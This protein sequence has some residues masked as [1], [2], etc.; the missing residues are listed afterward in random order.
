M[1]A[2]GNAPLTP[3]GRLDTVR[4]VAVG[5]RNIGRVARDVGVWGQTVRK[6]VR[7]FLEEGKAGLWDRSFRPR[8]SP[9]RCSPVVGQ[10]VVDAR[11]RLRAGPVRVAAATGATERTVTLILRRLF[12]PAAGGRCTGGETSPGSGW[13]TRSRA[14][15]VDALC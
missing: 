11:R 7:R 13:A 9:G 2:R 10:R 14:S 4:R 6:W 1:G 15:V 12:P 5:K 8:R 3:L